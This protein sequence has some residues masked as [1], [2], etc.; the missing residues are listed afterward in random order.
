[1]YFEGISK[2]LFFIAIGI[3]AIVGAVKKPRFF[4]E[5][6]KAR[7][8]RRIFGDKITSIFYTAIGLFLCGFGV[9]MFF[10]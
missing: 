2:G 8:M 4:W 7:S 6:R 1:M 3:F 10:Q 5:A 9:A